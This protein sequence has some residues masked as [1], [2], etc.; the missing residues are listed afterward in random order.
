MRG[1][2]AGAGLLRRRLQQ[3]IGRE[4]MGGLAV[5]GERRMDRR[6]LLE[7]L[8][9]RRLH[10]LAGKIRDEHA[11]DRHLGGPIERAGARD[12]V[13]R[14]D[15]ALAD[16]G[17]EIR[18][19]QSAAREAEGG[20][21]EGRVGL[22]DPIVDRLRRGGLAEA[23]ERERER[24]LRRR[25]AGQFGADAGELLGGALEVA[26]EEGD[27]AVQEPRLPV[28]GVGLPQARRSGS[29]RAHSRPGR[30]AGR[31]RH[32]SVRASADIA[33]AAR[34]AGARAGPA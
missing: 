8:G 22:A 30:R 15:H 25:L 31:S 18:A 23:L 27:A 19:R 33:G 12:P 4:Q 29:W 28:I 13:E 9:G 21:G 34:R 16:L 17:G 5:D 20:R 24:H 2:A 10:D 26:L 6:R 1:R 3:Q 32:R 11:H 14:L 7:F